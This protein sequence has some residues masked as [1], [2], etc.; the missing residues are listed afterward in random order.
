MQMKRVSPDLQGSAVAAVATAMTVL[1]AALVVLLFIQCLPHLRR[2]WEVTVGLVDDIERRGCESIA[3]AV[4]PEQTRLALAP[5]DQAGRDHHPLG[6]LYHVP[7]QYVLELSLH[8]IIR[9]RDRDEQEE[10][11]CF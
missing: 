11:A 1:R 2:H 10:P 3:D 4:D 9:F 6:S 8:A 7:Q 5:H